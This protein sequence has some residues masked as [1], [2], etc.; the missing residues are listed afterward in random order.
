MPFDESSWT[1][2]LTAPDTVTAEILVGRLRADGVEV[3]VRTDTAL[4]GSG[5]AC[6][7]LV[8]PGDLRRARSLLAESP[9]SSEELE[10]LALDAPPPK[11]D[12]T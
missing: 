3:S 9:V 7:L 11:D 4:L 10:R 5:R 12:R 2:L 6:R 1:T 8:A